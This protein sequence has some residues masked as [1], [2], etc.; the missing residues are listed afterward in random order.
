LVARSCA[1]SPDGELLA[2][3]SDDRTVRLWHV[4]GGTQRAVLTGRTDMVSG[5]AFSPDGE[6]LATASSDR[7]VRLWRVADGSV[8]AV[9]AGHTSWAEACSFSPDGELLATVSRDGALRLWHVAT[10]QCH[11]ALRIGDSLLGVAVAASAARRPAARCDPR[12][13]SRLRRSRDR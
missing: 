13:Q 10:R 5:C 2:T 12:P 6:L 8:I 11:C 1:F 9:L 4:A 7:T 3:T